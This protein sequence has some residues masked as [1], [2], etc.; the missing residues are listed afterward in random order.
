MS[1]WPLLKPWESTEQP[2]PRWKT[3]KQQYKTEEIN[4]FPTCL[5]ILLNYFFWCA[6]EGGWWGS[7]SHSCCYQGW[8]SPSNQT[9]MVGLMLSSRTSDTRYQHLPCL[10]EQIWWDGQ[11]ISVQNSSQTVTTCC[12][13]R[14]NLSLTSNENIQPIQAPW[15]HLKSQGSFP[16]TNSACYQLIWSSSPW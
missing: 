11:S 10:W 7:C 8:A 3:T 16:A 2:E 1:C 12:C 9:V 15:N 14:Q 4:Y 5:S 6:F 13:P